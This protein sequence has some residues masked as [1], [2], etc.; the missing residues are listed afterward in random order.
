M[1]LS[2]GV[3]IAIAVVLGAIP[4]SVREG[5]Y[6]CGSL[7][8]PVGAEDLPWEVR[9]WVPNLCDAATNTRLILTLVV[10]ILGLALIAAGAMTAKNAE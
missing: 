6:K 2:G 10:A 7:L 3:F 1:K 5:Q 9:S 4:V 8:A